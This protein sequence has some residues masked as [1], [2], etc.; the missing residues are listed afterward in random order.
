MAFWNTIYYGTFDAFDAPAQYSIEIAKKNYEGDPFELL[1]SSVPV[2]QEWQEDDPKAP[3]RGCNLTVRMI[4]KILNGIEASFSLADFYSEEDDAFVVYLY[5]NT[6]GVKLFKGYIVQD[7]CKEIQVDFA[8]EIVISATDNLGLLKERRLNQAA[9]IIGDVLSVEAAIIFQANHT[10]YISIA[11]SDPLPFGIGDVISIYVL[12]GALIASY[13]VQNIGAY[14]SLLGWP[15]TV[16]EEVN[17]IALSFYDLS[18]VVPQN[19]SGYLSLKDILEICL[20]SLNLT[21]GLR[22]YSQLYPIGGST[23]R[24]IDD[25][26]ILGESFIE[27]G[28][29]LPCYTILERIMQRF[30]SSLFQCNGNWT[31]VRWGELWRYTTVDGATIGGYVY[32]FNFDFV[33]TT[34]SQQNFHF[35]DGQDV[36]VGLLRSINRPLQ[37]I[38]DTFNYVQPESLLCNYDLQKLGGLVSV[39]EDLVNLTIIKDYN[40]ICWFNDTIYPI[41]TFAT[42]LIRIIYNNDP[43]SNE[44]NNELD[45]YMVLYGIT[46]SYESRA[47]VSTPIEVNAG[48]I[49]E[50]SFDIRA[51]NTYINDLS[52]TKYHIE[53]ETISTRY[54]VN[55]NQWL[56]F[57]DEY[58]TW[59]AFSTSTIQIGPPRGF[60]QKEWRNFKVVIKPCPEDGLLYIILPQLETPP[61]T[62]YETYISNMSITIRNTLDSNRRTI[63][64]QHTDIQLPNLIIKNNEQTDIYF[65]DSFR[66]TIG[67][68]LFLDSYTGLI[69]TRTGKW[70]YTGAV[71]SQSLGQIVTV[72]QLFQRWYAKD[73]YNGTTTY[74]KNNDGWIINPMSVF[75]DSQNPE[76]KRYVTGSISVDYKNSAAGFTIYEIDNSDRTMAEFNL[77]NLYQFNY[78]YEKS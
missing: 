1:L 75:L 56:T 61:V 35:K 21:L 49:I 46:P 42:K 40:I 72:E 76:L 33:N 25:T 77:N 55:F 8:H 78:L 12:G 18:Y 14:D 39:T 57:N 23:G 36:E 6:N 38:Q 43:S 26:Y 67:G 28:E 31:I 65:D 32:N 52:T 47:A 3:I 71:L 16:V 54:G 19:I 64:H 73:I 44:Y 74:I 24:W 70:N 48:D 2:T 60:D 53:L 51:N 29:Y 63:G 30:R 41:P 59:G 66:S 69:R 7:D 17:D 5:D 50:F 20:K 37:Y 58:G 62:T 45:R 9:I 34:T 68:T 4:A 22:V 27:N 10:I 11:L 13:T 15:V